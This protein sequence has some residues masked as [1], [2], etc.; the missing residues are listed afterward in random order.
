M[1]GELIKFLRRYCSVPTQPS[2]SSRI[3]PRPMPRAI[4]RHISFLEVRSSFRNTRKIFA[5]WVKG[6]SKILG[7]G[8]YNRLPSGIQAKVKAKVVARMLKED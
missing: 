6:R 4:P 1:R 2:R 3:P 8:L 7:T 5:Q